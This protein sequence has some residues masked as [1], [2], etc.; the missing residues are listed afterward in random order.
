MRKEKSK[1][2]MFWQ[3]GTL[4]FV[5]LWAGSYAAVWM[6][7]WAVLEANVIRGLSNEQTNI[8]AISFITLGAALLQVQVVERL[9]KHSMRGWMLYTIVGTLLTFLTFHDLSGSDARMILTKLSLLVPAPLIQTVW[10]WRRV[11]AA[12]LWPLASV[13]A[14]MVFVLPL[15]SEYSGSSQTLLVIAALL[16]GLIQGGVMRYLWLQPKETVTEKAKFDI[17]TDRYTDQA[18]TQRLQSSEAP[19]KPLAYQDERISQRESQ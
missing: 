7:L 11:K 15:R 16:Y 17:G 3:A 6:A 9:L 8:F 10:L 14:A 5:A 12:C 19:V 13:A 18:R 1:N 2:D 4:P